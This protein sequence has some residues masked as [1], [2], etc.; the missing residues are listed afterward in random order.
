MQQYLRIKAQHPDMLLFYRMGDFYELFYDDARRAAEL[1]DITLTA[2]GKSSG[3][4]VPMAGVPYHAVEGY[5]ARLLRLGESVALCEQ[6]GDP[7]SS[8]GPVER[9]VQRIL[10]PGTVT[11]EALLEE[12]K[13]TLLVAVHRRDDRYGF[14]ALDLGGGRF[15]LSEVRGLDAA[16][17]ELA[18]LAPA[19][20]LFDEEQD[21]DAGLQ[22]R[23]AT[24][25]R[26]PWHF[27]TR[28]AA[29]H[30]A[31]QFGVRDLSGFGCVDMPAATG[32]AGC[33][34][35]YVRETQKSQLPHITGLRTE[36]PA[37]A[38]II[39]AASRRNLELETSLGGNPKATLL[40]VLDRT[41]TAM[42]SRLL[43]RMMN[44]PIRDLVILEARQDAVETLLSERVHEP[45]RDTLQRIGD[46]ER[47]LTRVALGTARPRD[48]ASLTASLR[49]LPQ[50]R[51]TLAPH[52][53]QRLQTL[54][55]TVGEFPELVDL[56]TRALIESP[57][58][59][60]REGGVIAP[61]YDTELDEL[62]TLSDDA[63]AFL[64]QM[65]ARERERTGIGNLKVG[66]N[67]VHGFYIEISRTQAQNA[68]EDYTRRQ[69]LKSAERFITQELKAFED[70]VLSARERALSREKALYEA[71]LQ[72]LLEPLP[73][74]QR[75]AQ[76]IAEIDVLGCFAERAATLNFV[77]PQ[78][79]AQ[80][81]IELRQARHPVVEA[82][83][84]S[85]F[86]ANDCVL[87]DPHRML[88]ITGPNMGGKSTYM[89]QVAL[90]VIMAHMGS[91]LPVSTAR[92]GPVDR[93]FT[94][95]GAADDLAGGRSTFMVE[96]TETANILHNAS[97]DSLVLMDEVGRGTSTL[98]GL[99]LAWSTAYAL[100]R[101][102]R[103]YSLFATHYFEL[104][105]LAEQCEGIANVHLDAAEHG[106]DIV[107]L[108]AVEPGPANQ[109]YGIQVARLAGI[110]KPVI[111]AARAKL[112]ELESGVVNVSAISAPDQIS[113][114]PAAQPSAALDYLDTLDPNE[115]TPRDALETLYRLHT[116]RSAERRKR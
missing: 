43:R 101:Q 100:A 3:A 99:S 26:P 39:D 92:I 60:I 94:R 76:A 96:M 14:A 57:P 25:G 68:P 18:R 27:D 107:F 5:L 65:E 37:D 51:S 109:S 86:I 6:V 71:L 47:V 32:A 66:Y 84:D 104:T 77:R 21:L 22:L 29:Q 116:L 4:P 56:L 30:L 44:R 31:Q 28:G 70:K 40:S 12:R 73:A 64:Q 105:T 16:R 103:C 13:D 112:N 79:S 75:S 97:A 1:L 110:P 85:A 72:K 2:R 50:L 63:G 53:C 106:D 19:E 11:D 67:R 24:R 98:D 80:P 17:D 81:G 58:A 8:K 114:F 95:I 115:I 62:R 83:L 46:V 41:A 34:L 108:Y 42:G 69:T 48:L 54:Q 36:Q 49:E 35:Q 78:M 61:G 82:M 59:V 7:A 15:S 93:V 102:Q 87:E 55:A 20:L 10:T 88:V 89:R 91:F 33:V 45:L 52:E 23:G 111:D 113:L 9:Q 74:L 90:L 38:V